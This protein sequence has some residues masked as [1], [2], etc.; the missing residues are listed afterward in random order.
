MID[1]IWSVGLVASL[2]L[3][4]II[5]TLYIFW[6]QRARRFQPPPAVIVTRCEAG[7]PIAS[8]WKSCP[9]CD[10]LRRAS[11]SDPAPAS[12]ERVT[13]ITGVPL[14][15]SATKAPAGTSNL[16]HFNAF[17]PHRIVPGAQFILDIWAHSAAD[18]LRT[19]ESARQLMRD[20]NVGRKA[21]VEI[22]ADSVLSVAVKIPGMRV[23][24]GIEIMTWHG[25]PTNVSFAVQVPLNICIGAHIGWA[26]VSIADIAVAKLTFS[27]LISKE[28]NKRLTNRS[29]KLVFPKNAFASY[30][31]EDRLEVFHRIQGIKT[32][33]PNLDIFVDVL[34][35]RAGQ[36]WLE[37]LEKHIPSKDIFYLFWS[38]EASVSPW[39]TTEWQMALDRRGLDYIHP[40]PLTSPQL[41]PPPPALASLHFGE[42]E[43]ISIMAQRHINEVAAEN[44]N[45]RGV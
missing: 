35:L 37:E 13:G 29:E 14:R 40:V 39:V 42:A 18:Y 10:A 9:Y 16:I 17:T 23:T 36:H 27:I 33:C 43:L 30:A 38:R 32:I 44:S 21:A 28:S 4:A 1:R 8:N 15:R 31:S 3:V 26:T 45:S 25:E 34:S 24:S 22:F 5:I 7:H 2:I 6:R 12:V 41:A 11:F 19:C 20:V